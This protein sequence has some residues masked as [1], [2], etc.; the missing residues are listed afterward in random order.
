MAN[1]YWFISEDDEIVAVYDDIEVVREEL[2]YRREDNPTG[3][4]RAYGLTQVELEDYS[5]E[6]DF[7]KSE[8]LLK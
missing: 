4:Y 3:I 5:D 7:V 2:F 1:K 8:G 6:Y